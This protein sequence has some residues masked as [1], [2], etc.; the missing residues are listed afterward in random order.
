MAENLVSKNLGVGSATVHTQVIAVNLQYRIKDG[1]IELHILMSGDITLAK[2]H[3]HADSIE[4]QLKEKFGENTHVAIH[5]EPKE[6]ET[7]T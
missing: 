3:D 5:M 4:N 2:A 7:P 6:T 1:G